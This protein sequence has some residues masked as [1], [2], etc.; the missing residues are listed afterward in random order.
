MRNHFAILAIVLSLSGCET[1]GGAGANFDINSSPEYK[2]HQM[3]LGRQTYVYS[4]AEG[5]P[6]ELGIIASSACNS[7]RAALYSAI[8][9]AKGPAFARG[10]TDSSEREDPK[11]IAGA[12]IKVRQ[13]QQPF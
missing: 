8:A 10:Y 4:K 13:G 11:M 3:C 12:I 6:L 2:E 5:S 9:A 7:T 1:S